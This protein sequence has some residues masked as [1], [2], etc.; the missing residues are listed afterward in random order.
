MRGR[1]RAAHAAIRV[2]RAAAV[3]TED[4]MARYPPAAGV[5]L[6]AILA[7]ADPFGAALAVRVESVD[8]RSGH[9]ARRFDRGGAAVR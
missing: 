8:Q 5:A 2:A 3:P 1:R 6:V 7:S 9:R 4:V